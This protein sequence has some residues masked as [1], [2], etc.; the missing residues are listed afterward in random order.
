MVHFPREIEH[1][2]KYYDTNFE[3]KHVI[4]PKDLYDRMPKC[5]LLSESE[6]R[7][8]GVTQS[9]GWQHYTIHRPEPH[10]LLFKRPLGTNPMTGEV[11]TY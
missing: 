7:K 8:L 9:R 4:L 10:I 6:W 2:D 1:S 5:R 3:F 11:N